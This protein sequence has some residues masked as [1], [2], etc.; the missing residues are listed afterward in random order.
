MNIK[1]TYKVFLF[2]LSLPVFLFNMSG[3]VY[4]ATP[5]FTTYPSNAAVS[6][7]EYFVNPGVTIY[8]QLTIANLDASRKIK[9]SLDAIM[10]DREGYFTFSEKELEIAPQNKKVI[11]FSTVVPASLC[12]G[13][14]KGLIA[15][16]LYSYDG[17]ESKGGLMAGFSV[18]NPIVINV[19]A[20]TQTDTE[21]CTTVYPLSLTGTA[22]TIWTYPTGVPLNVV[23]PFATNDFTSSSDGGAYV[24]ASKSKVTPVGLPE[25]KFKPLDQFKFEEGVEAYDF[26][27]FFDQQFAD[28]EI[29]L[30]ETF[31][32]KVNEILEVID[33][34]IQELSV[35]VEESRK[36]LVFV[37]ENVIKNENGEPYTGVITSPMKIDPKEI[38]EVNLPE[39]KEIVS[40]ILRIGLEDK[41]IYFEK[42][43]AILFDISELIIE[44]GRNYK[45]YYLEKKEQAWELAGDGGKIIK[46]SSGNVFVFLTVDH[47]TDFAVFKEIVPAED[48]FCEFEDIEDHWAQSY[49]AYFCEQGLVMGYEDELFWPDKSVTRAEFLK[50]VM[51]A[52]KV[53]DDD[54]GGEVYFLDVKNHWVLPLLRLSQSKNVIEGYSDNTFRPDKP[55]QRVEALKILLESLA[56]DLET[57]LISTYKD[58]QQG[59][60]YMK[61]LNFATDRAFVHG[62]GDGTFGPGRS[63]TRAEALKIIYKALEYAKL[64]VVE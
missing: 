41:S 34:K 14:Y 49:I 21:N 60:W 11:N 63:I 48:F 58:I 64:L 13:K 15:V 12:P 53:K 16:L 59:S 30:L 52:L 57:D 51:L 33:G 20:T 56:V 62:Y 3:M 36:A 7:Y 28:L 22:Y 61:Y 31:G 40:D 1:E 4:S 17:F 23:Y 26:D 55:T 9:I 38:A 19:Q 35:F 24:P 44:D 45:V 47:F 5:L 27:K 10:A 54:N 6:I 43:V 18:A 8:D 37:G 46:D 50:M 29:V 42:P 2:F 39:K 32:E 25:I